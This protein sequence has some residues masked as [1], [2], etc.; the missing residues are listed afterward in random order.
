MPVELHGQSAEHAGCRDYPYDADDGPRD[1]AVSDRRADQTR[2]QSSPPPIPTPLCEIHPET[3]RQLC[4]L[5]GTATTV[6][7]TTRRGTAR[8]LRARFSPRYTPRH[9]VRT[10]PLDGG[11]ASVNRLTIAVLDPISR[12]PE[13]KGCAVRV[14][15]ACRPAFRTLSPN[16]SFMIVLHAAFPE[17]N[18]FEFTGTGLTSPALL[19]PSGWP[20]G[21]HRRSGA[22]RWCIFAPATARPR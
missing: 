3:A 6:R 15:R 20:T 4:A 14:D 18:A 21:C 7:L 8:M 1:G 13:Y 17:R 16:E 22:R 19:H 5:P 2:A 9:A 10:V 11:D 12:I